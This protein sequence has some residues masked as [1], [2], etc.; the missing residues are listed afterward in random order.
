MKQKLILTIAA[1]LASGQSAFAQTF[2]YTHQ[3]KTLYYTVQTDGVEV[4]GYDNLYIPYTGDLIIPDTVENEG[5][6]Y[7]VIS[8]SQEAFNNCSGL[9]SV[10]I[11]SPVTSIGELAF[12]N[13]S[14]LTSIVFN[15]DSC[16]TSLS[17]Y[18]YNVFSG[19]TNITNFTFGNN[20]KSIPEYIC[21]DL[22]GLTSV[23]I[24]NSVSNIGGWAFKNCSGLTSVVI[25][26]SV[27][28]IGTAAFSYC[29]GL[30]SIVFNADSCIS[31]GGEGNSAFKGCSNITNFILGDNVKRIPIYLFAW[32]N[33]LTS[34]TIP[35]SVRSIG[36]MAFAYCSELTSITIPELVGNI[37]EV[38][39][40]NCTSLD[41]IIMLS[42]NP[43]TITY[44]TFQTIPTNIPIIVPCGSTETYNNAAY[45]NV[46]TNIQ[47][48]DS[49]NNQ[50][51]VD[52]VE[53][54]DA[55]VYSSNGQIVI[56][57]AEGNMVTLYDLNGRMIATK[58]DY[59]VPIRF[60]APSSGTYMI[61]IGN[62]PARKVVVIR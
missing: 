54:V 28:N 10:T 56:E 51:G 50:D 3:G 52:R 9:T 62:H 55:E 45:W 39:F 13:C 8:I 32:E 34:I 26:N 40:G 61:K 23:T 7:A 15:A 12:G 6:Q 60:D 31:A 14:G 22:S 59:G 35:T 37:G 33:G 25:P 19:C 43:P 24:P 42:E 18:N 36:H 30:T 38:A 17:G 21:C 49:C 48:S 20:V 44:N 46:F 41:T 47:E 16:I 57:G 53:M 2:A 11:P 27:D 29:S 5:T 4:I 1:L 58:Q